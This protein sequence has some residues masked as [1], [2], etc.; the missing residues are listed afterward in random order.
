MALISSRTVGCLV[1]GRPRPDCTSP[2][3]DPDHH[4]HG[5]TIETEDQVM[6]DEKKKELGTYDVEQSSGVTATYQLNEEDAKRMGAKKRSGSAASSD[7]SSPQAKAR[8]AP[9]K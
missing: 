6:G 7:D 4:E 3:H 5:V 8:S 2:G 9:N 1:C